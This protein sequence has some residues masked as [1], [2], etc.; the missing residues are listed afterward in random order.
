MNRPDV[1]GDKRLP[2]R[3]DDRDSARNRRLEKDRDVLLGRS[4]ENF[5][6][7]LGQ[8]SLVGGD[9]DLALLDCGEDELERKLDAAHQFDGDLHLGILNDVLPA[10]RQHGRRRHQRTGPLM[11]EVRDFADGQFQPEPFAKQPSI[12]DQVLV[13][14]RANGAEACDADA[15]LSH[16]GGRILRGEGAIGKWGERQSG[17][18]HQDSIVRP[19]GIPWG[20]VR[21]AVELELHHQDRIGHFVDR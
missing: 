4:L 17:L 18:P 7:V 13:N 21:R 5:S 16:K 12:P 8:Q 3:L 6:A 2:Q 10:F 20:G 19:V 11:V 14:A 1:I 15:D 9:D